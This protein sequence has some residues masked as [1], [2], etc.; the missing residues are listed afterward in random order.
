MARRR[1][2]D[3]GGMSLFPFMSIL[4]GLV[5]ILTLLISVLSRQKE[6]EKP[7][8]DTAAATRAAEKRQLD[9]KARQLERELAALAERIKKE[10]A[11][12]QKV[13]DLRDRRIVLQDELAGLK[14]SAG[15]SDAEL[16]KIIELLRREI[17]ALEK[18]K[19]VLVRRVQEL[20]K[21][22]KA[23]KE[24]PEP[25]KSVQVRPGGSGLHRATNVFFVECHSTGI[26]LIRKGQEPLRIGTSAIANSVD[27]RRFL[28]AIK[29][30]RD[31]MVLFLIRK[32]G[33]PSY[34]WAAAEASKRFQLRIGK[35]PLPNDGP[36]DLSL[37]D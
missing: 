36:L 1:N 7:Q 11:G 8:E 6:P 10:R 17:T 16:Q 37:F 12:Q 5:G 9:S 34:L 26:T 14:K 31:P 24:A 22:I 29:E 15:S 3:D 19:P 25:P 35:L 2:R 13:I 28:A 27:Y 21:L 32:A 33:H 4:A 23:R 20:E 30:E 18:D